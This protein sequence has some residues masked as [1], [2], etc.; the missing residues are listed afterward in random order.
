MPLGALPFFGNASL[1]SI[2]GGAGG[3]ISSLTNQIP[4]NERHSGIFRA[5][6]LFLLGFPR[7]VQRMKFVR[8]PRSGQGQMPAARACLNAVQQPRHLRARLRMVW[9]PSRPASHH[10]DS[11]RGPCSSRWSPP[12]PC[13]NT[14]VLAQSVDWRWCLPAGRRPP[15]PG[16]PAK[17]LPPA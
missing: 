5:W 3:G 15:R 8:W 7:T 4:Y 14:E 17:A 16:F 9:S 2:A 1:R 13:W 12:L 6:S 11:G 10:R